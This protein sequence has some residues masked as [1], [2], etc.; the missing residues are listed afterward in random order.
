MAKDL[1]SSSIDRHNILNNELALIEIQNKSSFTG[2]LWNGE[3]MFTREMVS[4]LFEVDIR[5]IGRYIEQYNDELTKNGYQVLKGKRLKEFLKEMRASFGKDIN[6]P[7][8][9][10]VLGVFNFR[11]FLNLA[12]LLSESEKA[13]ILRQ[14]MLDIVID[15][16]NQK[17]GGGT[18]YINQ[19]DKDFISASLQEDNYRRIFTDALKLYVV[20]DHYKYAHFTDMIYISIFKEKASE[21]K[22]ILDLK[23]SD[24]VRDTFYSEILDIIAAYE[25]GLAD[26]IKDEYEKH[27]SLL[28]RTEVENIFSDFEKLALWKPLIHRGRIKMASRDM[29][30]RDAFHYQLSEYIQPLNKDEYQKFLGAAGDELDRL[31]EENKDV[32]KR[33]KERE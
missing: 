10:T 16:I 32:L 28:S 12:M 6:V 22:K 19:R 13:K 30:L 5:T 3:I 33:L 2:V 25:C 9:T 24:K 17:T 23:A 14:M 21:Y 11:S 1:T 31:M 15:L 4:E 20:D 18:K 29:A 8:K 27:G 26:A 7:T